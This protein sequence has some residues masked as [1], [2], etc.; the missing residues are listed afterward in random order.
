MLQLERRDLS[1][2]EVNYLFEIEVQNYII[3]LNCFESNLD[4]TK[5][6]ALNVNIT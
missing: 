6:C 4:N 5:V 1:W 3:G 2:Y